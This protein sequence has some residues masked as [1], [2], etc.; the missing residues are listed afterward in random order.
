MSAEPQPTVEPAVE[1]KT[2]RLPRQFRRLERWT[3]FLLLL[4]VII[5]GLVEWEVRTSRLSAMFFHNFAKQLVYGLDSGENPNA[6]FPRH[7]PYDERLGYTRIPALTTRLKTQG[8]EVL[9]QSRLSPPHL[10][11]VASGFYPIYHEKSQA[12]LEIFDEKGERL[13]SAR[14]PESAYHSFEDIPDVVVKTLLFIEDQKLLDQRFPYRNPAV[15]WSRLVRAVWEKGTSLLM[16]DRG[17]PGG[18][19]LATQMEKFKHSPDGLT[20]KPG[21]KFIQMVSASLRSFQDSE[22]TLEQRKEIVV[23]YINSVPSGAK[24]VFGEVLGLGSGLKAWYGNDFNRVNTLLKDLGDPAAGDIDEKAKAYKQVLSLFLAHRRPGY[25]LQSRPQALA[26]LTDRYLNALTKGKIISPEFAAVVRKTEI[27][28]APDHA[29]A[30]RE[31]VS[32]LERKSANAIRL[33]LLS[34]LGLKDLY[35]FDRFDMKVDS[36][37]NQDAQREVTRILSELRNPEKAKDFGLREPHLLETGDPSKVLYSF[38]LMER[39]GDRNLLRVQT[40]SLDGPFNLNESGKLELGSTAK[41]RVLVSY[42]QVMEK[43]HGEFSILTPEKL[44]VVETHDALSNWVKAQLLADPQMLLADLL[45]HALERN[46]SASTAEAFISGGAMHRFSNFNPDD[47][48]KHPSVLLAF[49][50]SMNLPFV[51][52]LRDVV[53][54]HMNQ[55]PD[56]PA[57]IKDTEHPLRASL[58]E[59]FSDRESQLFLLRPYRKYKGKSLTEAL[60]LLAPTLKPTHRAFAV[61]FRT[62]NPKGS[63]DEMR[64]YVTKYIAK[65]LPSKV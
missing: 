62:I 58:L 32:F 43:L 31:D 14:Q 64:D 57:V 28:L 65:P 46:Y 9:Q 41:L 44:Q 7:G 45:S 39:V 4:T 15:E 17:V 16:R 19:T 8:Y 59:R 20:K 35:E 49:T 29:K 50:K 52:I 23:N 12:G 55:M 5:I 48:W 40:D 42:M 37:I 63:L 18:S 1:S 61:A 51:R 36:T 10:G 26:D 30:K 33:H 24:P 22:Q 54:Y 13:F 60:D 34:Q 27:Q 47:N 3:A 2:I 56:Y 53:D 6:F 25:Y 21:D 38:V 11:Y